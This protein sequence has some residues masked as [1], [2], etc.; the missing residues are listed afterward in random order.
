MNSGGHYGVARAVFL[1]K[2]DKQINCYNPKAKDFSGTT[3]EIGENEALIGV[4]G[5]KDKENF[6][7]SFGYIV[8]TK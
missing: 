8:L 3:R 6:F 2:D 7:T 4:Y 5:V 1:D